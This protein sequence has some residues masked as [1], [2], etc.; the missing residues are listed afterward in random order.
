MFG[1]QSAFLV[2]PPPTF[3]LRTGHSPGGGASPIVYDV[4]M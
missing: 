3:D 1:H 2:P 4:M